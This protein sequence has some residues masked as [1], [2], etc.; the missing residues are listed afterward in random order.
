MFSQYIE[1]DPRPLSDI[2][3]CTQERLATLVK[4]GENERETS[5]TTNFETKRERQESL[6][7]T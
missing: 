6:L 2:T 1:H 4:S 3:P 5:N 7:Q